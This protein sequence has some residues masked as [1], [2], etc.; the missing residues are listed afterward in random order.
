MMVLFLATGGISMIGYQQ[1]PKRILEKKIRIG[2]IDDLASNYRDVLYAK[3]INCYNNGFYRLEFIEPYAINSNCQLS[4]HRAQTI[5][6]N[7]V[8]MH[9]TI[10]LERRVKSTSHP[11]LHV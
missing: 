8:T 11:C 2:S 9:C 3:I 6:D 1:K 7:R 4:R 5:F 10:M